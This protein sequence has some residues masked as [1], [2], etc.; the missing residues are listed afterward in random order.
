MRPKLVAGALYAALLA[1]AALAFAEE[2][3][4]FHDVPCGASEE[5]L[6]WRIRIQSC[7]PIA[8]AVEFGA[9]RCR[10]SRSVTFGDITPH[11]VF[12]YFRND[13]LVAWQVITPPRLREQVAKS[14]IAQYGHPTVV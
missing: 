14:L 1:V 4:G 5:L 12:F 10:A 3:K 6:R 9:R 11:A 13:M 2:P 8:P 7:D